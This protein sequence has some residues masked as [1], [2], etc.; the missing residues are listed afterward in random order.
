MFQDPQQ[1]QTSNPAV[2][3]CIIPSRPVQTNVTHLPP[4]RFIFQFEDPGSINHLVVFL[5]GIVPL[6]EGY[7]ASIHFQFP[8]K[9]DWQLLGMLSGT[10]PSAIFRLKGT[11]VPSQLDWA[12]SGMTDMPTALATLGIL[13]GP[14]AEIEAECGAL[15]TALTVRGP[16]AGSQPSTSSLPQLA[17]AIGLNLFRYLASFSSTTFDNQ[18]WI[19]ISVLEKWWKQFEFKLANSINP[20]QWLLE[21]AS[22]G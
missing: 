9:P 14:L 6:P 1:Q 13:V 21:S 20:E 4:N 17:K 3:A 15:N 5:T 2:F 18:T 8:N 11:M 16:S 7:G 19:P 22:A 10:K 12:S